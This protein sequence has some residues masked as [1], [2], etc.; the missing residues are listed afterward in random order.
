[1]YKVK[2]LKNTK[3]DIK[4]KIVYEDTKKEF[5]INVYLIDDSDIYSITAF[6]SSN[7][8]ILNGF[9]DSNGGTIEG[10]IYEGSFIE[11]EHL[12]ESILNVLYNK[13]N[14]LISCK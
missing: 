9:F 4:F 1:M 2:I 10:F 12:E 5:P 8:K 3:K 11:N 6:S 13:F 7:E 14:G